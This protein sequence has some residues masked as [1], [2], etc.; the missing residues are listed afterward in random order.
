MVL[1]SHKGRS[2]VVGDKAN[3][4]SGFIVKHVGVLNEATENS[5][6]ALDFKLVH[7]HVV[8]EISQRSMRTRCKSIIW[9]VSLN[10]SIALGSTIGDETGSD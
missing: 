2:S 3:G 7:T 6:I 1:Y 8:S 5:D 9:L 10:C 4:V